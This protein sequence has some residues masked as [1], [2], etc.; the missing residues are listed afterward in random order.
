MSESANEIAEDSAESYKERAERA[1]WK[2][3]ELDSFF[4]RISHDLKGPITSLISLDV[5]SRESIDDENTLRFMDMSIKQVYR[6][7]QILDELTK[8]TR[9]DRQEEAIQE[10]N[11]QKVVDE[12]LISL[13]TLPNFEKIAFEQIIDSDIKYRAPWALINTILRNLLENGIIYARPNEEN[14]FVKI[15]IEMNGDDV[16]IIVVDNGIGLKESEGKNIFDMFYR[17]KQEGGTGMGLYILSHAVKRLNGTVAVD[18]EV[19]KGSTFTISLP[20]N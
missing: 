5:I 11:F 19:E 10:I 8:L 12:C 17:V 16:Q 9:I 6:I 13:S 2:N 3:K 14:P 20:S 18:S 15:N 4:H 7:N 1:E